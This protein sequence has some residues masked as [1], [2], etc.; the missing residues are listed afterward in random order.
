MPFN[1]CDTYAS[2]NRGKDTDKMGNFKVIE[3]QEELD[4]LISDRLARERSKYADYEDLKLKA[5]EFDGQ[6]AKLNETNK[7][8]EEKVLASTALIDDLNKKVNAYE[9]DSVKT[10]VCLDL[11][12]PYEMAKRLNGVNEDEIRNDAENM[13]GLFSSYRVAPIASPEAQI[14]NSKEDSLRE[15]ANSLKK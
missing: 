7:A 1:K 13:K 3:T 11:G 14:S 6:V 10:K 9:I 8:L 4:E 12:L 2:K 5:A 15:L